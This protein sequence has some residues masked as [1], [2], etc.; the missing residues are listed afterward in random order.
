VGQ[1][2]RMAVRAV[3]EAPPLL[4]AAP[5]PTA[6]RRHPLVSGLVWGALTPIAMPMVAMVALQVRSEQVLA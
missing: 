4:Q 5:A 3:P 1:P 2:W 6:V